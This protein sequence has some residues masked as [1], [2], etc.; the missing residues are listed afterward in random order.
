MPG[1]KVILVGIATT[2]KNLVVEFTLGEVRARR[3]HTLRVPLRLLLDTDIIARL[4]NVE[5]LRLK[6][7]WLRGQAP[8]PPWDD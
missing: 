5:A 7:H 1:L 2:E 6:Q 3:V 4:S 8:L